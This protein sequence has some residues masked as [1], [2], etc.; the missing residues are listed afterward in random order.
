MTPAVIFDLDGTLIDSLADLRIA[1]N[2]LL[3]EEGRGALDDDDVRPMIGDGAAKLVER[4]F[5]ATGGPPPGDLAALTGRF[6]AFYEGEAAENTRPWPGVV[7][8]LRTLKSEGWRLA[9]CTNKPQMATEEILDQLGLASFFEAIVGG[10]RTPWKK[11]DPRHMLAALEAMGASR[12]GAVVV[13]DSPN[14][15]AAARDAGLPVIAV[16]FGYSRV[17]AA[18]LGADLLLDD[19]AGVPEAV[20]RL[21][22]ARPN[23][24]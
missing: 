7:E 11:P 15:V 12:D 24:S 8:A 23:P 22:A 21:A 1:L 20:R 6:L 9:V 19:F 4:G 17:P 10:D 18:E 13:G 16:T 14:D 3:N 2:R 5:A